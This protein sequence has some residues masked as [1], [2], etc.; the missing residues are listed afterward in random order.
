MLAFSYC[1][2]L[3]AIT[4]PANVTSIG[5]FAF[6][7]CSSLTSIT[8]L[9]ST[10]PSMNGEEIFTESP[11]KNIYVPTGSSA[12]YESLKGKHGISADV[13]ISEI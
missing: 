5:D 10:P 8:F 4:I 3:T 2:K 12:A 13:V 6:K 1:D 9:S 11:L 7:K